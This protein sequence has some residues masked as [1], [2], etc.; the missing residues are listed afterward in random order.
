MIFNWLEARQALGNLANGH[1]IEEPAMLRLLLPAGWWCGGISQTTQPSYHDKMRLIN[2]DTLKLEEFIGSDTPKY[3]IL[4]HTWGNDEVSFQEYNW[5]HEH[6]QEV[7][8]GIIDEMLPR[9]RKRVEA[10][11]TALRERS[12][13]AKIRSFARLARH[14]R[15][16][17]TTHLLQ[18]NRRWRNNKRCAGT[19][20]IWVDTCCIN[21][22]SSAELSEAINSMFRWYAN[23]SVCVTYL[24]D[25]YGD[26]LELIEDEFAASRWF[27]RGWTL[28]ELIAP[29]ELLFY[30]RD[31]NFICRKY[32]GPAA[33]ILEAITG[34]NAGIFNHK[35]PIHDETGAK[36]MSWAANRQTTRVEDMAYCLLGILDVNMPLL[37]GEGPRAFHRLQQEYIQSRFDWSIFA[38]GYQ[39]PINPQAIPLIAADAPNDIFAGSP[40]CFKACGG[41]SNNVLGTNQQD[42]FAKLWGDILDLPYRLTNIGLEMTALITSVP[43]G[44][45][46]LV[47]TYAIL[48]AR[49][50]DFVIC[51][52][53][54]DISGRP[55][56]P[57]RIPDNQPLVRPHFEQPTLIFRRP[58]N[59]DWYFKTVQRSVMVERSYGMRV[60]YD[61]QFYGS[62]KFLASCSVLSG[63]QLLETWSSF[64]V[65]C[66][67]E[68][69]MT[70]TGSVES[71]NVNFVGSRKMQSSELSD[72]IF[73][74][75]RKERS[76]LNVEREFVIAIKMKP[77]M[78]GIKWVYIMDWKKKLESLSCPSL[79]SRFLEPRLAQA[80]WWEKRWDELEV[81]SGLNITNRKELLKGIS[82]A[83]DIEYL[84]H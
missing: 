58:P 55:F 36:R 30:N 2:I 71:V 65:P 37:Y 48:P 24:T 31:W 52:P 4:S 73:F 39:Q 38:W 22:E 26:N 68:T 10:K 67:A 12:G 44:R 74:R 46:G 33:E 64:M 60:T 82:F 9:Q 6:D 62:D 5:L 56:D 27:T 50:R 80:S 76:G 63:L 25:V 35:K 70:S 29:R 77:R 15:D 32:D 3:F 47:R 17:G 78:E 7:A 51:M 84:G 21:K 34:I 14:L 23:A 8:D 43:F 11:A 28:Q 81:N 54:L 79:C 59:G 61:S 19:S 83:I 16:G 49:I 72:P 41:V 75:V 45:Q 69:D 13:Y 53:L 42:R 18:G 66:W 1:G 20:H 57:D 40:A